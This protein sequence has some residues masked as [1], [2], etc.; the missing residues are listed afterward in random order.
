MNRG[1][2]IAGTGTDVGKTYVAALLVKKLLACGVKTGYYKA[3]IS[4]ADSVQNSDAGYVNRTA[5]L[6]QDPKTLLSYLYKTAVSPHL[7]ARIEEKPLSLQK[8]KDDFESVHRARGFTVAE[9][10]GGIVCPLRWDD[11][12]HVLLEDVVVS[13]GLDVLLVADAGLGTINATTLTV[14]YL[15]GRGIGVKGILLNRYADCVMHRDNKTMIEAL[16]QTPV[17]ACVREGAEELELPANA[18]RDLTGE[19][20]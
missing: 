16:T 5:G 8:V 4:G 3:A 13:L 19:K 14:K 12:A 9:G 15:R 1:V 6:K 7:A 20:V 2:F 17:L 11:A 10:S 18:L